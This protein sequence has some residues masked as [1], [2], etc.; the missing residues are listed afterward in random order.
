MSI[1]RPNERGRRESGQ[2]DTAP[3]EHAVVLNDGETPV[4]TD[5]DVPVVTN[6]GG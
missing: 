6:A 3:R 1:R 2:G 4:V 5:S